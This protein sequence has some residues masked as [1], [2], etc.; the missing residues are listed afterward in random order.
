MASVVQPGNGTVTIG[1]AGANLSYRPAGDYCN[2]GGPTPDTFAYTLN[3]GSSAKVSVTVT[4][5]DD[6]PAAVDDS[7]DVAQGATAAPI[8]VL[9][10]DLDFDGGP[11]SVESIS[12]PSH[13]T[14]AIAGAGE[15]L[16]Y[17]PAAGYCNDGEAPDG[18]T[19]TL[20]GGST[21][22]VAVEVSCVTT[23]TTDQGL[24]P[25]FDPEASDYTV[26]CDGSP[27]EVLGRTAA[28]AAVSI[29]GQA[30]ESGPFE[31]S[32]PL[33]A[34][35]EF[36]FSLDEGGQQ[37]DYHVR[38]LP[39]DF[40]V[41]EYEGLLEAQHPFYMLTTNVAAPAGHYV[42]VFD[43]RGVPVWWYDEGPKPTDAK[44]LDD[45]TFAWFQS[46]ETGYVIRQPDGTPVRTVGFVGGESD[47]HDLQKLQNGNF[48]ITSYLPRQ[49]VDLTA[50]GGG[51]DDSVTDAVI[52]EIGP[53]GELLWKW[54]TEDHVGLAE[55]GRWWPQALKTPDRDIVHINAVEPD[56]A[57]NAILISLRHTDGVYKIDKATGEVIW[58]L[59]RDLDFEEPDA[60]RR[61]RGRLPAG[62]P[63]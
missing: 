53:A 15:S 55:T 49:H 11:L 51:P 58:K 14:V 24:V 38:C 62:R 19:Y 50:F 27:L 22:N 10:N 3:G 63:A 8:L 30:A 2:S 4:C 21:A 34:N 28:G 43:E 17:A 37:R 32:V 12:Q 41:L 16:T 26:R 45:G 61:P 23:L 13:G 56:E 42:V 44:F 47:F 46:E 35:Q 9:G 18:F 60:G 48:L 57:D 33:Q 54:S 5:V 31:I 59:R 1:A 40:P 36:G 39:S 7:A 25:Q 52:E 29:D 20:N 6:P